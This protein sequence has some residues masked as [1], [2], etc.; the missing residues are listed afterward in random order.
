MFIDTT[1]T[2]KDQES[3]TILPVFHVLKRNFSGDVVLPGDG[4][5]EQLSS[6]MAGK[7]APALIVRPNDAADVSTAVL[8]ARQNSLAISVRSGGHGSAGFGTNDGGIVIDLAKIKSVEVVD[9]EKKLV[10][11]GAGAVWSNVAGEL[12]KYGLAVSSGDTKSVGVGGLTLGGGIGWLVRLYGLTID[13][14]TGAEI[15]T[16]DGS[17]LNVS[18]TDH[19]DLFWALKGGGGNFGIVTHFEFEAR[20]VGRIT[21]GKVEYDF[22]D[23]EKVLKNWRDT[24]RNAPDGLNSTVGIMPPLFGNPPALQVLFC[25]PDT[26]NDDVKNIIA[27]VLRLGR[28]NRQDVQEM[29]YADILEEPMKLPDTLKAVMKNTFTENFSDDLI[30]KIAAAS[31]LP[32][33]PGIQIRSMGG[34]MKRID[35][36]STPFAFR[37]SEVIYG[38]GTIVPAGI[39]PE[40]LK[41][42]LRHWD[43]IGPFGKGSYVNFLS[44][45]EN[46][47]DVYP[48]PVYARL[49]KIKKTY[50][51]DNVFRLNYNIRPD[52]D[53]TQLEFR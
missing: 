37:N 17:V 41:H 22:G 29:N 11:I 8:F 31:G 51:P 4:A 39:S 30:A 50:D 45:K 5:Y 18:T 48:G 21:A 35:P 26:Y 46:I 13:H 38:S 6:V 23:L 20:S 15:V 12:G 49:R 42:A 34:A 9:L 14:L 52:D 53:Q 24:M 43:S 27:P 47:E 1:V 19:P 33:S 2:A 28:V 16:A 40:G 10:R 7:G 25:Y 3:T 36:D 32:D 44:E